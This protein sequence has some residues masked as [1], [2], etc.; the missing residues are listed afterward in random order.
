M[1][2]QYCYEEPALNYGKRGYKWEKR[3]SETFLRPPQDR[4]KL[5]ANPVLKGGNVLCPHG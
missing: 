3:R 1:P 5:F 4:V 2:L